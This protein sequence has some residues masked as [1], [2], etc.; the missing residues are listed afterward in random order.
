MSRKHIG[1]IYTGGTVGMARTEQGY[2]PM[3]DFAAVLAR[4]LDSHGEALPRHTLHAYPAPID[5]TNAT[6]QDWQA[7]G[8]DIAARYDDY[9]G[10]VVL[11]GTD[12]MAYTA[13]ALSYML[14]GLRKP[15]IVTGSQIP[16]GS[17]RS[18]A[19]QNL[20]TSLQLAACDELH[21]VAICFG[22]R[23]LR[24]NRA[25][26]IS[27]GQLEAFDSPNYPGLADIGIDIALNTPAL[28]PKPGTERFELP[29]YTDALVLPV[30][31]VPGMP[32]RVVQVMLELA[33]RALILECY[34]SGNAP[35]RDP[36]LLHM[37]GEA[38]RQGIVVVACSQ[39][40][41]GGV[42]IGTYAAGA[43]M[44]AAGVIGASDMTFEAIYVKLHHLLALGLSTG[45][46]RER[47]LQ[48]LSGELSL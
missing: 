46:L 5:S 38:S 37:L 47:F 4:L 43:G 19:A 29:V 23:L 39:S 14:Q 36:A 24:G 48:N 27:T 28:F 41:H 20:I 10:F 32:V 3:L 22:K 30:R 18:D 42:E 33:P 15:V 8:R 16:L 26:K 45:A 9:D 44:K 17:P 13:T 12:T 31:F 6:P 35:D 21:E 2:A 25:T 40:L 34:G 11:H 1:L 7:I